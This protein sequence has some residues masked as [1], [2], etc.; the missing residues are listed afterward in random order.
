[1]LLCLVQIPVSFLTW[2]VVFVI[3]WIG[4]TCWFLQ[5]LLELLDQVEDVIAVDT[6]APSI[7][8]EEDSSELRGR[9]GNTLTTRFDSAAMKVPKKIPDTVMKTSPCDFLVLEVYFTFSNRVHLQ[10]CSSFSF[11]LMIYIDTID[12]TCAKG[13]REM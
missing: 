4:Y 12:Y 8:L 11:L 5:A 10:D 3:S 6:V 7:D 13:N 9:N 2:W 1:M